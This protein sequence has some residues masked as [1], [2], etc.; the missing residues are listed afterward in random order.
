MAHI[1]DLL[2]HASFMFY[3]TI[4]FIGALVFTAWLNRY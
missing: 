4:M 2:T 3:F 1:V